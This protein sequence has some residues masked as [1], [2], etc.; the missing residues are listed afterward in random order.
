MAAREA[1]SSEAMTRG[2]GV[3]A[4]PASRFNVDAPKAPPPAA[5]ADPAAAE[6]ARLRAARRPGPVS[7]G[8]RGPGPCT[9]SSRKSVRARARVAPAP[10]SA[11][12]AEARDGDGRRRGRR[13]RDGQDAPARGRPAEERPHDRGPK[14]RRVEVTDRKSRRPGRP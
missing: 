9:R 11:A 14:G 4:P 10:A 12:P 6:V 13:R 3:H 7:D 5:R 8:R 1:A 2:A